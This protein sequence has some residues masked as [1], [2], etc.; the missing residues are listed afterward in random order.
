MIPANKQAV[1]H[2][3]KLKINEQINETEVIVLR[4]EDL[5]IPG[6]EDSDVVLEVLNSRP[7][8]RD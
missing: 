8:I 2:Q 6:L 5:F 3:N 1:L 7:D 4:E